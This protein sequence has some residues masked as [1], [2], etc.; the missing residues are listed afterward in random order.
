MKPDEKTVTMPMAEYE[1]LMKMKKA[2]SEDKVLVKKTTYGYG[3]T[4]TIEF[5]LPKEDAFEDI[6]KSR[7]DLLIQNKQL[8]KTNEEL[9][10]RK[11]A[12]N[13]FTNRL[14]FLFTGELEYIS[15]KEQ[16]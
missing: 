1:E 15:Y 11:I 16:S 13:N 14:R 7:D 3:A 4:N 8:A 5:Y 12:D 9:S 6:A 2:M 10:I